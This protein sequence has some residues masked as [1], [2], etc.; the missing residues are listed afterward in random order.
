MPFASLAAVV[1]LVL[2]APSPQ[3]SAMIRGRVT[4]AVTGDPIPRAVVR[5]A[6]LGPGSQKWDALASDDGRFVF[7]NVPAGSFRLWAEPPAGVTTH[8][9]RSFGQSVRFD[10][11]RH[12]VIREPLRLSGGEEFVAAIELPHAVTVAGRVADANGLPA[13]NVRVVV[14]DLKGYVAARQATST[15][16]DGRFS[17]PGVRPGEYSVC[18]VPGV[19]P[20]L[21]R[22][23]GRFEGEQ[24]LETCYPFDSTAPRPNQ[25]PDLGITLRYGPLFSIAGAIL[26]ATGSPL[27]TNSFQITR[28]D[29][30][31]VASVDIQ[32]AGGQFVIRGVRPGEYHLAARRVTVEGQTI[33][34][35]LLPV[36]ID[37]ADVENVVVRTM[38]P[39][40]IVGRVE[41]AE[42]VPGVRP[43]VNVNT[44][45][46]R[47][48][49]VGPFENVSHVGSDST[50]RLDGLI[51]PQM[52]QVFGAM[53]PWAV[54]RDSVPGRRH[55]R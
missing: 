25:L 45:G 27:A 50:F 46:Q 28:L 36:R 37:T 5:L 14:R 41:Y 24:P 55:L 7:P 33:E 29:G 54:S 13:R 49:P 51:G 12:D 23:P 38:P 20:A 42:G 6:F 40:S 43:V 16:A 44:N 48:R 32:H 3:S 4:D 11:D 21:R 10:P 17:V 8:V 52:F 19:G 18:A 39:V 15:D 53:K 34:S 26:D 1:A 47:I 9:S 35:G 31:S 2:A 22:A 30:S